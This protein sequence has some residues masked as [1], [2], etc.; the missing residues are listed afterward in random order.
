MVQQSRRQ[1]S[2]SLANLYCNAA[3]EH[4]FLLLVK[5][6]SFTE[7]WSINATITRRI[8]LQISREK[9]M[10]SFQPSALKRGL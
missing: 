1:D 6:W 3:V 8:L 5:L 2:E 7:Y 4:T 9:Q 10:Q